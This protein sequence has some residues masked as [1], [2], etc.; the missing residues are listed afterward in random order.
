MKLDFDFGEKT[1]LKDWWKQVRD[2]FSAVQEAVNSHISDFENAKTEIDNTITE[3]VAEERQNRISADEEL[4]GKISDEKNERA[5]AENSLDM[6]IREE[7]TKRAKADADLNNLF[8]KEKEIRQSGD[9]A[10]LQKNQR[11][12]IG[13]E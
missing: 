12:N 1:L 6:R 5:E 9:E 8:E 7:V 4:S 3:R 2:N 11:R 10:V 13:K